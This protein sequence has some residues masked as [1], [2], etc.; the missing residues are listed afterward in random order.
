MR[1]KSQFLFILIA[2][3]FLWTIIFTAGSAFATELTQTD[4]SGVKSGVTV[5]AQTFCISTKSA[6]PPDSKCKYKLGTYPKPADLAK[7][8]AM[9]KRANK[10]ESDGKFDNVPI[11]PQR[12][13]SI[14]TQL[15]IWKE[16][17]ENSDKK[18]DKVSQTSI[19]DDLLSASQT[20]KSSLTDEQKANFDSNI[21]KIFAA[22]DLTQKVGLVPVE[23][24]TQKSQSSDEISPCSSLDNTICGELADKVEKGQLKVELT[25]DGISTTHVEL[26]LENLTDRPMLVTIPEGQVFVPESQEYQYMIIREKSTASLPPGIDKS[27]KL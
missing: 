22:A 25:G 19:G 16:Q 1:F 6:K 14:L 24:E 8:K 9:L 15:A 20:K 7:F 3:G 5:Q 18:E 13:V 12:R 10:L 17:G 23:D 4:T 27:T 11:H 2:T 21:A 26:Q